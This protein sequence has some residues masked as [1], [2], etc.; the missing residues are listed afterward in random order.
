MFS[1]S[2]N[3]LLQCALSISY[4]SLLLSFHVLIY[5]SAIILLDTYPY[6]RYLET[7]DA[8]SNRQIWPRRTKQSRSKANRVLPRECT[9]H[10]KHSLPTTQE[11]TLHMDI[12]SWSIPKWDW[13]YSMQPKMEKL[14]RVN[15][16]KTRSWLWLTSWTPYCQ[17]QTY[18][19]ESKENH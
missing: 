13:F 4:F 2:I 9:G 3:L 7:R 11:K 15:K 19:E 14:Y 8:W 12:T 5:S 18:I 6:I 16:N 10:S 1:K 17:I